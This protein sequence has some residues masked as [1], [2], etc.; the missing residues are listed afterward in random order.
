MPEDDRK[1]TLNVGQNYVEL[2]GFYGGDMSHA[3]SAW[4]STS[5]ELT[6]QKRARIPA[7]LRM[8]ADNGHGTPFEKSSLHFLVTTDI[9]THIHTLKHRIGVSLN[10]ES[11]RYKELRDDRLYLPPDWLEEEQREYVELMTRCYEA[12]HRQLARM[13]AR[14]VDRR[15]AKDSA[16]FYMPYGSQLT[17]DVMFNFRSFDHF[18]RLRY[19][20]H[21]QL[22]VRE[23]AAAMLKMTK[24][25]G[26]FDHSLAAFG[27]TDELGNIRGPFDGPE[28]P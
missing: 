2:L 28:E 18:L 23:V 9:A 14:G 21:A 22:E 15:R 20:Y 3:M 5:R 19:S 7:L 1:P 16:R 12:Y 25:T 6:D 10:G 27:Y 17:S 26:A 8:L 11:A 13:V 24:L 4:T